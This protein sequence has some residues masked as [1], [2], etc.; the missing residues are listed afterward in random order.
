MWQNIF[1]S[2]SWQWLPAWALL[3]Y[4]EYLENS[5]SWQQDQYLNEQIFSLKEYFVDKKIFRQAYEY[6]K[7]IFWTNVLFKKKIFRQPAMAPCASSSSPKAGKPRQHLIPVA[8]LLLFVIMVVIVFAI[9][10]VARWTHLVNIW[11]LQKYCYC[12]NHCF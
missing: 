1:Y 10:L 7:R 4:P 6:S 3:E 8:I 5:H 12:F 11:Y 9:V 2:G